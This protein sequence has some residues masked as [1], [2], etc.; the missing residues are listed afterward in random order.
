MTNSMTE[1]RR[2][3][4]LI[5]VLAVFFL[6]MA[7]SLNSLLASFISG[8]FFSALLEVALTKSKEE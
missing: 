6:F 7:F 2:A 5:A 8:F 4:W 1:H 3:V